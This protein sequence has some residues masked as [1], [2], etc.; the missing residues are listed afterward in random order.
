MVDVLGQVRLTGYGLAP[1]HADPKL[2]A[3]I[4]DPTW[5]APELIKSPHAATVETESKP[6]DVF[7]FGMLGIE[8]YTGK[9]PFKES[10]GT[11]LLRQI[12][13]GVRPEPPPDSE[14]IGLTCS[15]WELFQSCWHKDPRERPTVDEVVRSCENPL[16]SDRCPPRTMDNQ[17]RGGPVPDADIF[18]G[19][20]KPVPLPPLQISGGQP[21]HPGKR[22]TPFL[23]ITN[24]SVC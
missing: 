24:S 10:S 12:L 7:A 3:T 23:T 11:K 2:V 22:P 19:A 17:S 1:L 16:G 13:D 8:V 20:A 15:V 21:T 4:E 5:F 6:A 18:P 9:P 14:A